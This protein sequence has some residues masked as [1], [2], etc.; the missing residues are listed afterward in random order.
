MKTKEFLYADK[1]QQ[2]IRANHFMALANTAYYLYVMVMLLISVMQGV[3]STGFAGLI[4]TMVV[5]ALSVTWIVYKRNP[6]SKKMKY[7]VIIGLCL[8]GWIISF[9]YSQDFAVIIGIF[10]I[11]CSVLYFDVKY[12]LISGAAYTAVA[13]FA[14]FYKMSTKQNIGDNTVVDFIF[15][16]SA[17]V[18][19]TAIVTLTTSVAKVF[20]NHS[21]G[22]AIAEQERQKEIMNDVLSVAEEV[23]SGTENAMEIINLLNE[24]SEVVNG[25]M[26]DIS[27]STLNT[28]ESIQTQTTMTQSIQES[29]DITIQSSESMVQMAQQSDAMNQQNL[30]LMDSLKQQSG[31]IAATNSEVAE[32]MKALQERTNA[33]KGI[34]DTIFSISSQ[35]N[36][37]ALNASIES[38]RAGEAGRGFAVVADEIRQLA[39]KTR[40]ETEN[41]A[42]ILDE[43]SKN[44]K[45][46]AETVERSV[47][48]TNVQDE[49]IE[50]VSMSFEEMSKNVNGLITEIANIDGLLGSLSEANNQIVENIT[51]LSAT[52]EEVTASSVQATEIT[53][54]NLSHAEHAKEE[55]TNILNV[56]HQLDKYM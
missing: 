50:K 29:L 41:I 8:I 42:K 7:I 5:I 47:E 12:S 48:A 26:R 2:L 39:E 16:I 15:V 55:L 9:A 10:S 21:T 11:V 14:V 40:I 33:V 1:E 49:M 52:T 45:E 31:I 32:S 38:A 20:N 43:L 30:Q 46:A 19:F 13:T 17:L 28:S 34:A 56:S 18:L 37:L 22:A 24:S 54:E 6:K 44:A 51:N 25:A 23:R 53:V 36:L 35:T 4:A 27:D 3:R